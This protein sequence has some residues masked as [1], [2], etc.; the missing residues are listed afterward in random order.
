MTKAPLTAE[1]RDAVEAVLTFSA[2][3]PEK[4]GGMPSMFNCELILGVTTNHL[5]H[6]DKYLINK[7]RQLT[8]N[9]KG[10]Y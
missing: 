5:K 6:K 2:P 1:K 9:K 3:L 4:A 8:S 10:I 7:L